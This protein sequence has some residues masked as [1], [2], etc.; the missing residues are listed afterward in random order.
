M[1]S[2]RSASEL[3][4]SPLKKA[5]SATKHA[6][7]YVYGLIACGARDNTALTIVPK[8]LVPTVVRVPVAAAPTHVAPTQHPKVQDFEQPA[9]RR[10]KLPTA[11]QFDPTE[12]GLVYLRNASNPYPLPSDI[13]CCAGFIYNGRKCPHSY[14]QCTLKHIYKASSNMSLMGGNG[15]HFLVTDSGWFDKGSFRGCHVK[16]KYKKLFGNKNGPFGG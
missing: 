12:K 8:P 15:D 2:G 10:I 5:V 6:C 9:A 14:G 1:E 13:D 16:D 4:I 7:N 11:P 3:D